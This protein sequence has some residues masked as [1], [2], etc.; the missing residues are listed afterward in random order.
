MQGGRR[1]RLPCPKSIQISHLATSLPTLLEQHGRYQIERPLFCSAL[2]S[3]PSNAR[4]NRAS[5]IAAILS[6]L[7][8]VFS[9]KKKT[10][11]SGLNHPKSG[12]KPPGDPP[13]WPHKWPA[14]NGP[15]HLHGLPKTTG[16]EV[17]D[18]H[19]PLTTLP[20]QPVPKPP[21]LRGLGIYG[22]GGRGGRVDV[23]ESRKEV[24]TR[25]PNLIVTA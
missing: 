15:R 20:W 22:R 19:G 5:R 13:N 24:K 4:L 18:C 1:S 14:L 3:P 21:G 23:E 7:V 10:S 2:R 8:G 16:I 9:S 17:S 25:R 11:V 6:D 12:L